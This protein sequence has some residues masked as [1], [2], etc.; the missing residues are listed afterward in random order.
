MEPKNRRFLITCLILIL[1]ACLGVIVVGV[2]AAGYFS[3]HSTSDVLSTV[4]CFNFPDKSLAADKN[5]QMDQIEEQVIAIRGLKPK[6]D[7]NRGFLTTA[8]LRQHV[9]DNFF[10]DYSAE[11]A[12]NDARELA[13]LGL[14]N[15][16]FDLIKF[17][18]DLYS[19]QIAGLYDQETKEM[20]VIQDEQF[21]GPE[22]MT[23]AHEYT[24]VLQDQNYDLENGLKLNEKACKED[25]ERCAAITALVEGDATTTESTWY[26]DDATKQDCQQITSFYSTL[27][28]PIYDSAPEFMQQ[29]FLFPYMQGKDFVQALIDRDGEVAVDDA[30]RDPP[31]STEQILHPDK[32]PTEPPVTV[33]LPGLGS[34]L[35][36]EWKEI[37]HGAMGEWYTYL[38]MA[39]GLNP[40]TRLDSDAAAKAAAGWGGDAYAVYFNAAQNQT[41]LV[42]QTTWDNQAEAQEFSKSFQDY[43]NQRFGQNTQ[44]E[45]NT[46]VGS[47]EASYFILQNS[48]STWIVAPDEA[49]ITTLKGALQLP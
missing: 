21:G 2:L 18:T 28:S 42:L 27:K 22:R 46:W 4:S 1:V 34:F 10:K 3:T 33:N 9:V 13:A 19:E 43:C 32:Y 23:Y 24:H 16:D 40:V 47:Q 35:G 39:Y 41:V 30:F 37:D 11:D 5:T 48:T 44:K 38:I 15:P 17:Y 26:K 49:I 12:Q 8:E 36:N 7:V 45:S 6:S 29:D 20:Y 25:S 14:L 31:L